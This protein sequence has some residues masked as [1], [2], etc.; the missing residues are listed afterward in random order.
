MVLTNHL[1]V[2]FII[3]TLQAEHRTKV[4]NA[5]RSH[6]NIRHGVPE[7]SI[8][9]F[10]VNIDICDSFLWDDKCDIASYADDNTLYTSDI[11]LDLVFEK[12]ENS[13]HDL[14]R[15]FKE[16]LM[17]PNPDKCHLLVTSNTPISVNMNGFHIISRTEEKLLGVKFDS[18][19]S[20]KN[21]DSSL[22]NKASQKLHARNRIVKYM[23][24]S[25]RK[26]IMKTFVIS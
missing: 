26:T 17:K 9:G 10:L 22:C 13:S 24:F 2:S 3:I 5:Y 11:S 1:F 21:H 19:L 16:N 7:G 15:W 20:F 25:K 4:N 6:A 12:L 14:F 8:S 23:D 18:K